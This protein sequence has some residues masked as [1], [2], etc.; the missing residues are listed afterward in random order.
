MKPFIV[1]VFF[2][3]KVGQFPFQ[4]GKMFSA[5]PRNL[6][7]YAYGR[8]NRSN[9]NMNRSNGN[10]SRFNSNTTRSNGEIN[11]SNGEIN[12]SNGEINRSNGY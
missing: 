4:L 6:C 8:T 5:P 9:G 7:P 3:S 2:I 11:R 12:R 1:I 10:V